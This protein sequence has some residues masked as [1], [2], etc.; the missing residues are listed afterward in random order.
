MEP[1]FW[2]ERWQRNEIGFHQHEFNSHLQ[3]FWPGLGLAAGSHVFVP[4]CGKSLDLLW[5][6]A[7]GHRVTGVEISPIAVRD[8]FREN[9]LD[10]SVRD[11]GAFARWEADGLTILCGDFFALAPACL[12]DVSGVFDRASLVALPESLRA[13]YAVHLT[14]ILPPAAQVLLVTMEYNQ[15]EMNGPPFAVPEYEVRALYEP[16]CRVQPLF[17]KNIIDD[18]PRFRERGLTALRERVYRITPSGG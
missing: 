9:A 6:R 2:I 14:T 3:E 8:F 1:Q 7:R 16:R 15:A 13:R 10:P 12:A 11:D 17:E 18:N 4:L 5:L